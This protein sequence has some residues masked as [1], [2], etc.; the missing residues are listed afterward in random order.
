M[1]IVRIVGQ[2]FINGVPAEVGSE[3]LPQDML[4]VRA[5]EVELEDGAVFISI[6]ARYCDLMGLNIESQIP[7]TSTVQSM[8]PTVTVTPEEEVVAPVVETPSKA[9]TL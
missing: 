2:V 1:K 3:V 9:P 5:A 6:C 8:E 7:S 4:D